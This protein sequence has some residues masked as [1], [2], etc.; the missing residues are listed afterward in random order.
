MAT[1]QDFEA[2][3]AC[4]TPQLVDVALDIVHSM[5][6]CSDPSMLEAFAVA[7]PSPKSIRLRARPYASISR[8][9]LRHSLVSCPHVESVALTS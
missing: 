6:E 5:W 9:F 4:P 7:F 8:A 3:V 1:H 2:L